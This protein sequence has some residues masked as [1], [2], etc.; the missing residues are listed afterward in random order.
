MAEKCLVR[1]EH[2]YQATTNDCILYKTLFR[3]SFGFLDKISQNIMQDF[4]AAA[5]FFSCFA[6]GL[7][8]GYGKP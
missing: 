3:G 4:F 2:T 7:Y 1:G 5:N 6:S 8:F